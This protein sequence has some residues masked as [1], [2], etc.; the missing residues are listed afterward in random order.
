M[1]FIEH[2][3]INFDERALV[4]FE[5]IIGMTLP[6]EY[7]DFLKKNNGGTP[8]LNTIELQNEEIKSFSINYFLGLDLDDIN[9]LQAQFLTY[10]Q[11]I[12]KKYIP[13][14]NVEGGN[15]VCLNIVNGSILLW[16]HDTELIN[17]STISYKSFLP[18]ANS[19]DEFLEMIKPYIEENYDEYEVEEV[20]I[21]PDFLRELE[22]GENE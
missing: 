8:E 18:I 3:K 7:V 1:V 13:I 11:R 2:S 14:A 17:H 4:N 21:D 19:F 20:W 12:Q 16:D 22:N 5:N 10:R 9:N 15:I 6:K